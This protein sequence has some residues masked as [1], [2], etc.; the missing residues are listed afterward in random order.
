[1]LKQLRQTLL[2]VE[3]VIMVKDQSKLRVEVNV[4]NVL[5]LPYSFFLLLSIL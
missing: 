1:M 2:Y 3:L 5:T 4:L